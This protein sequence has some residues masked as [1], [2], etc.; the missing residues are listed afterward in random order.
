MVKSKFIALMASKVSSLSHKDM[1]F[2]VN[3]ILTIMKQA[4]LNGQSIEIRGFGSMRLRYHK[5]RRARNPKTGAAVMVPGK[6]A[7]RFSPGKRLRERVNQGANLDK[8]T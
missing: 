3:G 1:E 6:F 2:I 8:E 7:L 4:T 5:P